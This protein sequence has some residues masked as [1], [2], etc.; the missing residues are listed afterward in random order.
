MKRKIIFLSLLILFSV[1][2]VACAS[3]ESGES[4]KSTNND[5][6]KSETATKETI[7]KAGPFDVKIG[8]PGF[9]AMSFVTFATEAK[10]LFKE[11]NIKPELIRV[12]PPSQ[13]IQALVAGSIDF[14]VT[15]ADVAIRAIEKGA[16][17]KIIMSE[18]DNAPFS[19]IG[20]LKIKE[21]TE[22]KTKAIAASNP[23]DGASVLL[24]YAL[25]QKNLS[26]PQDYD[27][28]TVGSSNERISALKT[29]GVSAAILAQ[30]FDFTAMEENFPLLAR[31][32]EI[33]P[34][35]SYMVVSTSENS[36]N[37]KKDMIRA[38]SAARQKMIAYIYD[39]KNEQE[40]SNLLKERSKVSD[41]AA[42][43][44]IQLFKKSNSFA[45]KLDV[46]KLQNFIN[47]MKSSGEQL[48]ADPSKYL[49]NM[50]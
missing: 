17:I 26:Y 31:I 36:I 47:I 28:L 12:D 10:G 11:E 44:T 4:K 34:S 43:K 29:G 9:S 20:A 1:I 19:I 32:N 33:L 13:T 45:N 22:L 7:T 6:K 23:T 48:S 42:K 5:T 41:D 15:S 49:Y 37:N 8:I 18:V 50:Q 16:K 40:M 38:F 27:I 14:S 24:R 46:A 21:L 2:F 3:K 30:P 39:D 25:Q 35:F